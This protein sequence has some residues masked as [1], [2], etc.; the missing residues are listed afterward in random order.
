MPAPSRGAAL[1]S[2]AVPEA[3]GADLAAVAVLGLSP[4][5]LSPMKWA[6]KHPFLPP[7]GGR[8]REGSAR[9]HEGQPAARGRGELGGDLD[10]PAGSASSPRG[11]SAVLFPH[12][13]PGG[14]FSSLS[15]ILRG[16]ESKENPAS[17]VKGDGP[18]P[19]CAL[20]LFSPP[21]F[22]FFF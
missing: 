15:S 22:F 10:G 5:F 9:L 1:A 6:W 2:G 14:L 4:G 3:L 7:I 18:S 21:R 13:T 8:D 17:V 19:R 12:G 20:S 11:G 16:E